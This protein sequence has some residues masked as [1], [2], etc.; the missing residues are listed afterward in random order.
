M[1]NFIHLGEVAFADD[2]AYVVLAPEVLQE[3]EVLEQFEP[4]LEWTASIASSV[5][6][7]GGEQYCLVAVPDDYALLQ[8]GVG[9]IAAASKLT[10]KHHCLRRPLQMYEVHLAILDVQNL[11][12]GRRVI[13]SFELVQFSFEEDEVPPF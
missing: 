4:F 2:V 1:R 9:Q 13:K 10:T 5:G 7:A 8:V 3:A 11:A 12:C 6:T